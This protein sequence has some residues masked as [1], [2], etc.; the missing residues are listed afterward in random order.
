MRRHAWLDSPNA[1]FSKAQV[2]KQLTENIASTDSMVV[3][4][5]AAA[6]Q[7]SQQFAAER[8]GHTCTMCDRFGDE[9]W[10]V[11]T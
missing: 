4:E 11:P 5:F 8:D 9:L 2:S 6:L 7:G 1:T 3:N 10:I